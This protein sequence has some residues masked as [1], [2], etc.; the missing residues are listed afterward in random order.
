[1]LI[2]NIMGLN[3]DQSQF[4]ATLLNNRFFEGAKMTSLKRWITNLGMTFEFV[5]GLVFGL[6]YCERDEDIDES[7]IVVHIG[8]ARVVLWLGDFE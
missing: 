4:Q 1:M 6:E 2:Q 7:A 8:P 3:G 5:N